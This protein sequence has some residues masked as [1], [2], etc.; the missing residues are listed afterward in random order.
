MPV[1]TISFW[2]FSTLAEEYF[3]EVEIKCLESFS[4]P[5]LLSFPRLP[6]LNPAD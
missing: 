1:A 6:F 3:K 5:L 2:F 4:S